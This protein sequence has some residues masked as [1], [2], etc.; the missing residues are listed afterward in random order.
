[1]GPRH[2][3]VGQ[4]KDL[5]GVIIMTLYNSFLD[6]DHNTEDK[7]KFHCSNVQQTETVWEKEVSSKPHHRQT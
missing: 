4:G 1:M 6:A 2:C 3:H 5:I 7:V